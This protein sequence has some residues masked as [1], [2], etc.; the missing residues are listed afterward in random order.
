M[1]HAN[2]KAHFDL[3]SRV[4]ST[5]DRRLIEAGRSKRGEPCG[6]GFVL[7]D[8][9]GGAVICD[10]LRDLKLELAWHINHRLNN[11]GPGAFNEAIEGGR[12][13][14]DEL[15]RVSPDVTKSLVEMEE[16]SR[17]G[18]KLPSSGMPSRSQ[19]RL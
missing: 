9:D 18:T 6:T 5:L 7:L 1:P 4:A 15:A 8:A 10:N 12:V 14:F 11:N 13:T 17:L 16:R 19:S 3:L 2:L